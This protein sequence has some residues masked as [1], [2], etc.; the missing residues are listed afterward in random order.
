MNTILQNL[1]K[2]S[3]VICLIF[4]QATQLSCLAK[5]PL[6]LPRFASI[7]ASK[8]HLRTGPGN[9]HPIIWIYHKQHLPVMIIAEYENWRQIEDYEGTTGW[10]HHSMLSGKRYVMVL[11]KNASLLHSDDRDATIKARLDYSILGLIK[12]IKP[13]MVNI[14]IDD[15]KGWIARSDI[16]GVLK[17]E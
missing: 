15:V 6:P 9:Q 16:W 13:A 11:Q 3:V 14:K 7:K 4:L 8:M 17:N 10:V 5:A 1:I 2:K 12:D